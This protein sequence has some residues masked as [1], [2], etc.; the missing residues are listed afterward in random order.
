VRRV[1]Q[2][3]RGI[4]Q[5]Y[6][7]DK[8]ITYLLYLELYKKHIEFI[9]IHKSTPKRYYPHDLC[10]PQ[11]QLFCPAGRI[12]LNSHRPPFFVVP[13]HCTRTGADG[14][15]GGGDSGSG[16]CPPS[17]LPDE[18]EEEDE[19][20][21][22]DERG[23]DTVDKDDNDDES[24]PESVAAGF[25][26]GFFGVGFFAGGAEP[27]AL[28]FAFFAA[29]LELAELPALLVALPSPDPPRFRLRVPDELAVA[30]AA[31]AG[32][33]ARGGIGTV[34]TVAK[35]RMGPS[36]TV[37]GAVLVEGVALLDVAGALLD[38]PVMLVDGAGALLDGPEDEE[39]NED[40]VD[41]E[42][43]GEWR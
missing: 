42:P 25:A 14:G 26:A 24:S 16:G 18:D 34:S 38:G 30:V 43:R 21:E 15:G 7:T 10:L 8:N 20:E 28:D 2:S 37:P 29:G 1:S 5:F 40:L 6:S 3:T 41:V 11:S 32:A 12:F 31:G 27:S 22:D 33:E 19:D 36:T 17:L 39:P 13:E 9:T 23:E 35:I 4:S